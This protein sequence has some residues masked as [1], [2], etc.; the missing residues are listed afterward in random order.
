[1][2]GSLTERIATLGINLPHLANHPLVLLVRQRRAFAGRAHRTQALGARCDLEL[3]LGAEGGHV[4]FAIF[5]TK[6]FGGLLGPL[7][8]TAGEFRLY[9][10]ARGDVLQNGVQV[11]QDFGV[12]RDRSVCL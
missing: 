8:H 12:C 7:A 10:R 9:R 1:M 4:E 11:G 3:D 5:P 2:A 6:F